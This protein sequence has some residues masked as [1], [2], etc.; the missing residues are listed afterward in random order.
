MAWPRPEL[1]NIERLSRREGEEF[2]FWIWQVYLTA[3]ETFKVE[4]SYWIFGAGAQEGKIGL[5]S[6]FK[7]IC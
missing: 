7:S 2:W 5:G 1:G 3:Y 6:M 4:M